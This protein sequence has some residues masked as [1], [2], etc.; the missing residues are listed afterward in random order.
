MDPIPI[1][2][3][4]ENKREEGRKGKVGDDGFRT[5]RA[6]D[7]LVEPPSASGVASQSPHSPLQ[8]IFLRP[9]F[10]CSGVVHSR[11][12]HCHRIGFWNIQAAMEETGCS[13]VTS[14]W[15][16]H[17]LACGLGSYRLR[18]KERPLY[19]IEASLALGKA[20]LN[21]GSPWA[22]CWRHHVV[23]DPAGQ[24]RKRNWH[25]T[26]LWSWQANSFLDPLPNGP[27]CGSS[28]PGQS[29]EHSTQLLGRPVSTAAAGAS[30]G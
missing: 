3:L 23:A 20:Q 14:Q 28:M 21:H 13:S 19:P 4:H 1:S 6:G 17:C 16:R 29:G 15:R 26:G 10:V 25:I 11:T 18:K 9:H 27:H 2:S 5:L 12:K 22:W 24:A 30:V 7:T 8:P